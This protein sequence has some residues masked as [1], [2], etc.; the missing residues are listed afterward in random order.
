MVGNGACLGPLI[1]GVWVVHI[2]HEDITLAVE[3]FGTMG[4]IPAAQFV[5]TFKIAIG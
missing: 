5:I 2:F 3:V 1:G 4:G